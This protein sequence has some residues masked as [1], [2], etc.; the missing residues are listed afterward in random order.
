MHGPRGLARHLQLAALQQGVQHGGARPKVRGQVRGL[1]VQA[2]QPLPG[3]RR[4][5]IPLHANF[6]KGQSVSQWGS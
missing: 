3:L 1:R 4:F 5:L 2:R 6:S